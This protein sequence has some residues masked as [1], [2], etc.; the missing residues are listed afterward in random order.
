MGDKI[1]RS[2]KPEN[3]V[4]QH[5]MFPTLLEA[6]KSP[7]LI[8]SDH[9]L[10]FASADFG[11]NKL[12]I[13]ILTLNI[14]GVGSPMSGFHVQGGWESENVSSSRYARIAKG[15]AAATE[16]QKADVILLQE[17]TSLQIIPLLKSQLPAGWN[18]V[19]DSSCGLITCFNGNRLSVESPEDAALDTKKRIRSLRFMDINDGKYVAV[20]NVWGIYDPFP[21]EMEADFKALLAK[22]EYAVIM[23][24]TNS[25]IAPVDDE[26]RNII[27]NIIPV[28]LNRSERL[29]LDIQRPD[30]PD[31]GFYRG[32][33]GILHQMQTRVL[34]FDSGELVDDNRKFDEI[35][36]WSEYRMV[37]CLDN[38]YCRQ[39][40]VDDK[41]IFEYQDYLK[42]V[43]NEPVICRMA[44][45]SFNH[46]AVAI[47]FTTNSSLYK[48]V[49]GQ[50]KEIPGFQHR[51]ISEA[52]DSGRSFPVI[53][54]PADQ[55]AALHE[56]LLH[57]Q[58]HVSG[59]KHSSSLFTPAAQVGSETGT[60]K[61]AESKNL[62]SRFDK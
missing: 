32:A 33:D 62:L 17:A 12:P 5:P 40:I 58:Q 8:Y 4:R 44:S 3:K 59:T 41:N 6:A 26:V 55:V 42:E 25:R 14:L 46:K 16:K 9:L 60:G 22:D 19:V 37:M 48:Y 43:C 23:G 1:M 30:F 54:V 20:H 35:R 53:F 45:D 49:V 2:S 57:Y 15:L 50:L 51:L 28:L 7:H 21:H 31:G 34:D 11:P 27:T 18:I 36:P 39:K 24:D 47:R 13:R 52:N 38:Y 56:T 29:P 10:M 61:S